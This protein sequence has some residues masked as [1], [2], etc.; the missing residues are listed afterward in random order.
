MILPSFPIVADKFTI[1]SSLTDDPTERELSGTL[2]DSFDLFF[3]PDSSSD[4]VPSG[5]LG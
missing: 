5:T 3:T 1:C 2:S 4:P